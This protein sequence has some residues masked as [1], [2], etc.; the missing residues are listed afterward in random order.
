MRRRR[1][2]REWVQHPIFVYGT[3]RPGQPN[4]GPFLGYYTVAI[5]PALIS[6][7]T[8]Y[9]LG[10]YPVMIEGKVDSQVRGEVIILHPAA[11]YRVRLRLDQLEGCAPGEETGLYRRVKRQVKLINSS[12]EALVWC[13]LGNPEALAKYP[14][15]PI[16]EGDWGGYLQERE[17]DLRTIGKR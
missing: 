13:Y 1:P 12:S 7:M 10:P 5:L 9:S 11:Y 3:L 14:H 8:L 16:P 2:P 6:G 15:T 17:A 4:Y